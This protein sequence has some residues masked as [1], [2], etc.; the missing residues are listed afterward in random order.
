LVALSKIVERLG[1][2]LLVAAALLDLQRTAV[3]VNRLLVLAQREIGDPEIVEGA[4]DTFLV[5][6]LLIDPERAPQGVDRLRELA[7]RIVGGPE[8][9]E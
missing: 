4:G 5:A 8:V 7:Q 9:I 1:D 6:Y 3:A 2:A